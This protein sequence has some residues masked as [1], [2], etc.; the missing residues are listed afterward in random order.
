MAIAG[1]REEIKSW[2]N[3]PG[4]W[5]ERL[6]TENIYIIPIVFAIEKQTSS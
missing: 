5:M 1:G 4:S 3:I 2:Q 6:N